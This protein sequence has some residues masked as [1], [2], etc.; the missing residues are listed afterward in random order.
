MHYYS[1]F[2]QPADEID[3][4]INLFLGRLLFGNRTESFFTFL[5]HQTYILGAWSE[6]RVYTTVYEFADKS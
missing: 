5:I 2:Q 1:L 3:K 6:N 4:R